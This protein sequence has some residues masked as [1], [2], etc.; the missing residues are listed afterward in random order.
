[1]RTPV[2]LV[3]K[4]TG[5][6]DE[7]KVKHY[8]GMPPELTGGKDLRE[9]LKP[10]DLVVIE[11]KEDGVFLIRFTADGEDVGDTWHMT[12]ED[13]KHQAQFEYG[14]LLAEWIEVPADVENAVSFGLNSG[15]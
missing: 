1:M 10:A 3:T 2:R 4:V 6:L 12:V 8:L 13:A 15:E 5:H 14:D 7:P 11:E 9:S